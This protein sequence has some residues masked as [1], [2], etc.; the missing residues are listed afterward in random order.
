MEAKYLKGENTNSGI[1]MT[2]YTQKNN[3]HDHLSAL[4]ELAKHNPIFQTYRLLMN[5]NLK[6]TLEQRT[7]LPTFKTSSFDLQDGTRLVVCFWCSLSHQ[8]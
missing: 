3:N 5:A 8:V 6:N 7:M 4:L 1:L 2:A